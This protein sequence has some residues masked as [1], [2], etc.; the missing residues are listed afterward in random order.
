[1][2]SLNLNHFLMHAHNLRRTAFIQQH[3]HGLHNEKQQTLV[4]LANAEVASRLDPL[5]FQVARLDQRGSCLAV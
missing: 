5:L 1:M 4:Q 2:K 3:R